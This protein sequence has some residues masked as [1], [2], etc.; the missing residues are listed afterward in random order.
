[1]K[2]ISLWNP[3]AEAMRLG[4]K[5]CETRSWPTEYRGDLII[6]SAKRRLDETG[7]SVALGQ[8]IPLTGMKFGFALCI[9]EICGCVST[10]RV[11]GFLPPLDKTELALGDYSPKRFVWLTQ[12]LRPLANPVPIVGH[13]GFWN[14]PTETVAAIT[15]NLP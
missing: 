8:Q 13:Q 12:N 10:E 4:L 14:L 15:A 9:V 1:M 2:A 7:L 6:C 11:Q 3:W 5:K